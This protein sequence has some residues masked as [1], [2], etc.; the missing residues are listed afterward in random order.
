MFPELSIVWPESP[1]LWQPV[2]YFLLGAVLFRVLGGYR[3]PTTDS[4]ITSTGS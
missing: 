3:Q 1:Q 2:A 4:G